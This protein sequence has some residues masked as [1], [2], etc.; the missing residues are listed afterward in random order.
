MKSLEGVGVAMVTPFD[1]N[2]N[3]DYP[4]LEKLTNHLIDQGA[5]YLVVQG[6]T[7]ESATL[8]T[9]E[10]KDVLQ[11]V[12]DVNA[13]RLPI[14]LGIGGNNTSL[15]LEQ[16]KSAD[17]N[18]VSAILSASPYYN[19]PTQEGIYQHFKVLAEASPLPIILYNVPGRTASNLTADTT[20]RLAR[21]FDKIIAIKEASA[22][23]DQVME[24]IEKKPADFMMISGEDAL[25]LP[26]IAC[27]GVGVISVVANAYPGQFAEMVRATRDGD[28][29]KARK[30][31]YLLLE[32]IG[33]LFSEGNPGGIKSALKAMGICED[34]LRLPLW[35]VSEELDQKI[36]AKVK[37]IGG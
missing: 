10:K 23:M 35:P 3:V 20:L 2:G 34:H 30:L 13:G 28:L 26:I 21:D 31:H 22:N 8:N 11:K 27:G 25:T 4:G 17:L 16:I 15:V 19:K 18:G 24:I 9:Q 7:G 33:L 37:S 6:T 32:F 12:K 29:E 14:V 5:D 1:S 36:A